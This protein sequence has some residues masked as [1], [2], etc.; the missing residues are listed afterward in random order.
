MHFSLAII[1]VSYI[2]NLYQSLLSSDVLVDYFFV[3]PLLCVVED[4]LLS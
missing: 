4:F 1:I 2:M 3:Y